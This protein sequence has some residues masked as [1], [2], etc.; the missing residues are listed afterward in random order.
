MHLLPSKIKFD[1][2]IRGFS[3]NLLKIRGWKI[4]SIEYPVLDVEFT[5]LQRQGFRVRMICDNWDDDPPSIQLLSSGGDKLVTVKRDP[6]GVINDSRHPHTGYPFICMRGSREYHT[7]SSH[8]TDHW[9]NYRGKSS[10]DLGGILSQ[11]WRAWM[12]T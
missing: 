11:I 8:V 2:Q 4:H 12:K 1:E 3:E 5:S 9:S 6:V 10:Y 7:H